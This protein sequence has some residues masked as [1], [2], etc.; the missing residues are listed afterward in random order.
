MIAAFALLRSARAR[1]PQWLSVGLPLLAVACG[2]GV[3]LGPFF[4]GAATMLDAGDAGARDDATIAVG[5]SASSDA[6]SLDA[7]FP[8]VPLLSIAVGDG[9]SCGVRQDGNAIC[10]GLNR[11]GQLGNGTATDSSVPLVVPKL[12]NVVQIALGAL[13]TC[14]VQRGGSVACWG[15][16]ALGQLGIGTQTSSYVPMFVPGLTDATQIAAMYFATCVLRKTGTV[17]CWG[18]S[19]AGQLADSATASRLNPGPVANLTDVTAISGAGSTMCALKRDGSVYC[20]GENTYGQ[21]GVPRA[22]AV[23]TQPSLVARLGAPAQAIAVGISHTCAV[24]T[25]ALLC[26]GQNASGQVGDGTQATSSDPGQAQGLTDVKGV[27]MGRNH[28]CAVTGTGATYC[29]G[30]NGNGELGNGETSRSNVPVLVPG[31]NATQLASYSDSS[32]ALLENGGAKCWGSNTSGRLG[33]GTPLFSTGPIALSDDPVV[34]EVGLGRDHAC[35]RL[36][37]GTAVACW[38]RASY[39]ASG[40]EGARATS[41]ARAV[42]GSDGVQG[43]ELG[44]RHSCGRRSGETF[45]WGDNTYGVMGNGV[46]SV[47]PKALAFPGAGGPVTSLQAGHLHQCALQGG[48]VVCLGRG[49]DGELGNGTLNIYQAAPAAVLRAGVE[50]TGVT[51]LVSG[52]YQSCA[53]TATEVLCWGYNVYHQ[54]NDGTDV[55]RNSATAMLPFPN[56]MPTS[57]ALGGYHGCAVFADSTVRCWG[58]GAYGGLG[59]GTFSTGSGQVAVSGLRDVKALALGEFH[60]CALHTDR[61]VSCWGQNEHGELGNGETTNAALPVVVRGLINV[62]ALRARGNRTC[63]LLTG[64]HL[65]CWGHNDHGQLGNGVVMQSNVPAA[66]VGL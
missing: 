10:W 16:N 8:K 14:A 18:Q 19:D 20:W 49:V 28:T 48:R 53:R 56:G 42:P 22:T 62:V 55:T 52:G 35:A 15:Y 33:L 58:Y 2:F 39:G 46:S 66:V 11:N 6:A 65:R 43:L 7:S 1:L 50:L 51:E 31:L 61:T 37:S 45:C 60:S 57:L 13:H 63:A 9:H 64:G 5:D 41:V 17:A 44:E 3:D 36:A 32:C 12:P 34:A 47:V 30:A 24:V 26:W 59:D 38:G 29:W 27:A 54:L 40:I 4:R 21:V 25:G 23:V